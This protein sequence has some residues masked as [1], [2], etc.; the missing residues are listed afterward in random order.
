MT[1][2]TSDQPTEHD[3]WYKYGVAFIIFEA[4]IAVAQT[5]FALYITLTG[6]R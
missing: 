4:S 5:V 2:T 6:A 3:R 1:K